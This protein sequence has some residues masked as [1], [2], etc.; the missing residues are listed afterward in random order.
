MYVKVTPIK[1]ENR[2]SIS[3]F[4]CSVPY[5]CVRWRTAISVYILK[6]RRSKIYT[7]GE[8]W[9]A[10]N[11]YTVTF[12]FSPLEDLLLWLSNNQLKC[13]EIQ[14][15]RE[16]FVTMMVLFTWLYIVITSTAYQFNKNLH[17]WWGVARV[18]QFLRI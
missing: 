13:I 9:R 18:K 11:D 5:R 1:S 17:D 6:Q 12:H 4:T 16:L 3:I 8:C 14:L 10:N 7:C 2:V 15:F